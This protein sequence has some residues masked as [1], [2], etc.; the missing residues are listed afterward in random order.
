MIVI[1]EGA[2]VENVSDA[3][4]EEG[5]TRAKDVVYAAA[6]DAE[7]CKSGVEGGGSVI[8]NCCIHLASTSHTTKGIEHTRAAKAN[9]SN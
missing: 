1:E 2:S 4:G 3:A 8:S 9:Q 5:E 7:Y 6:D